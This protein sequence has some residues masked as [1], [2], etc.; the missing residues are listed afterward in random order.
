MPKVKT[1][2]PQGQ[3]QYVCYTHNNPTLSP[4]DWSKKVNELFG[5]KLQYHVFGHEKVTTPHYQGYI[6]LK[7]SMRG[8]RI[9]EYLS[10]AHCEVRLGTQQQAIDYCGDP[11]KPGYVA[12]PWHTGT[13]IQTRQGERTDLHNALDTWVNEGELACS[14]KHLPVFVNSYRGLQRAVYL[15][16]LKTAGP[17]DIH[18][19]VLFGP[20]NV[21]KSHYAWMKEAELQP[22]VPM[23]FTMAPIKN[24][25][26]MEYEGQKAILF[27]EF[28]GNQDNK[29]PYTEFNMLLD[30]WPYFLNTK[31]GKEIARY[32]RIYISTNHHPRTWFRFDNDILRSTLIRRIHKV[33]HWNMNDS[34]P[35][36]PHDSEYSTPEEIKTFFDSF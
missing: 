14:E 25:Q 28:V 34:T 17:R 1:F 12:G 9:A 36:R 31:G 30:R 29:M 23:L 6:E 4:E 27:D 3:Y 5:D 24:Y 10:N 13:P 32:E 16:R 20:S 35:K 2:T 19:T 33:I 22:G 15:Q 8:K 18:V 11:N 7:Q 21:G 26:Y